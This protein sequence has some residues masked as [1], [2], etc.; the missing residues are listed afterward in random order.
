MART[1]S[2]IR[3]LVT[4]KDE[5][6]K[7]FKKLRVTVAG[8]ATAAGATA[9]AFGVKAV[10]S[11]MEA[12][13]QAAQLDAVLKSTN[14]AAGVTK[15]KALEL[16][17]A[18]QKQTT[19]SDEAVL[20]AE[21]M[22]L[23]FT[24]IKDNVFP[25]ATRTV[26]DMSTALGQDTKNSAIQLGKA[27]NDPILGVTALRRV[28]VDFTED[29]QKQIETLVRTG[30]TLDAQKLI[31]QELAKEFGGSAQAQAQTF[32]GRMKQLANTVDDLLE[33]IGEAIF[34]GLMPFLE[35][36]EEIANSP[37]AQQ[38]IEDLSKA[39]GTGLT[40]A[41]DAAAYAYQNY[42]KWASLAVNITK[43][44]MGVAEVILDPFGRFESAVKSLGKA[45]KGSAETGQFSW[46]GFLSWLEKSVK[47]G[48]DWINK[49]IAGYN[50][51]AGK[52]G[53]STISE[54]RYELGGPVMPGRSYIVG[55]KRPEVFVPTQSGNIKQTSQVGGGSVTVNFNNP[56]V[57][58]E[59]D[60]NRL[61]QVVKDTLA[62]DQ[63]MASFGIRTI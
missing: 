44:A 32:E 27:L 30:K 35:K 34:Q 12:Q 18:L 52:I 25:D 63:K 16:A 43:T 37:E 51:V 24:N 26:L 15:E 9:V 55:E 31:L 36:M 17:S 29:Q 56:V 3:L 62:R 5:A 6:S 21:N 39:I 48:I 50:K 10:K 1:D 28:G 22:L 53:K 23:T 13:K 2:E 42:H 19:Y 4:A 54:I 11:F 49:A 14:Q 47:K 57:R 38:A 58:D 45:F 33:K 8:L 40:K 20:S 61:V 7:T 59:Y 60:L 41:L 46:A